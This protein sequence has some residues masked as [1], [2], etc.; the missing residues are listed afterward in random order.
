MIVILNFKTAA[1]WRMESLLVL[2]ICSLRM[3][4]RS[5]EISICMAN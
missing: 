1:V 5:V 3:K 2:I 4:C